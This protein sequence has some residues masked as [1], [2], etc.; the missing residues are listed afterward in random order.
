MGVLSVQ[1]FNERRQRVIVRLLRQDARMALTL[2]AL[3]LSIKTWLYTHQI[4]IPGKRR[5]TRLAS[6]LYREAEQKL[7]DELH[8]EI[9]EGVRESWWYHLY[10]RMPEYGTQLEWLQQGPKKR[11]P[12]VIEDALNRLIL[13]RV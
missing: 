4:I 1:P 12:A 5:V 6:R 11:S 7:A 10:E 13:L 8:A 3:T 9:P 2:D